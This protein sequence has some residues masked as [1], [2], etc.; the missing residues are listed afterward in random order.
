VLYTT[1][2]PV[3]SNKIFQ[4]KPFNHSSPEKS[5]SLIDFPMDIFS[6]DIVIVGLGSIPGTGYAYSRL[7]I[8]QPGNLLQ[9]YELKGKA[10]H[11][12]RTLPFHLDRATLLLQL[13]IQP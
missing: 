7:R 1:P 2:N 9:D 10:I 8:Q 3:L 13:L 5:I 12:P 4:Q 11:V 6:L